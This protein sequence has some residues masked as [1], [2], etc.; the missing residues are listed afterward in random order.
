[1][2]GWV[3]RPEG[4]EDQLAIARVTA[5]AFAN[6]PRSD[7]REPAII[8]GL[9]QSGALFLSLVAQAGKA[10][11]GHAAFSAV[12]ISDGAQGWYGLGPLSVDPAWQSGGIGGDLVRAGLESLRQTGTAG[13]VV[14]GSPAYYGRFGFEHDPALVLPG[15]PP[16][17]FQRLVLNGRAPGG[18]VRY[19]PAFG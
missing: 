10:I 11:V 13:C 16:A 15:P 18:D 1:M 19:H 2:S 7:G 8:D 6:H 3:I 5:A 4:P 12:T 14:L 17:H 9:R